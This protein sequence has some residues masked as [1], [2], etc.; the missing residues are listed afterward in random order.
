M[1]NG[2]NDVEL[3]KLRNKAFYHMNYDG[4][5]FQK[6]WARKINSQKLRLKMLMQITE[7]CVPVPSNFSVLNVVQITV[8]VQFTT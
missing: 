4:F 5:F 1:G 2:I 3:D 8:H 6:L 7:L